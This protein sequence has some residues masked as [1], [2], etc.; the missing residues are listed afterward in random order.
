MPRQK[1]YIRENRVPLVLSDEE[2]QE[3]DALVVYDRSDRSAVL[4]D[5][6]RVAYERLQKEN[7][8]A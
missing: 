2:A 4:R 8:N 1:K 5:L 7:P 6:I 3:L